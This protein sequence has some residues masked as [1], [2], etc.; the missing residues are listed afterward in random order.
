VLSGIVITGGS[1]MTSATID[2]QIF[3]AAGRRGLPPRYSGALS[4]M[5]AQTRAATVIMKKPAIG[6]RKGSGRKSRQHAWPSKTGLW[7][8]LM[9]CLSRFFRPSLVPNPFREALI[10]RPDPLSSHVFTHPYLLHPNRRGSHE[11]I[12]MIEI[13]ESKARRSR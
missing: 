12:E 7:G 8:I 11:S 5:V 13:T 9:A 3:S 10:H 1:A 6:E 2:K 4:D